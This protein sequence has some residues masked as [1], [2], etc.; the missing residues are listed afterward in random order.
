[1]AASL[2]ATANLTDEEPEQQSSSKCLLK[3]IQLSKCASQLDDVKTFFE[4]IA[5]ESLTDTAVVDLWYNNR[6]AFDNQYMAIFNAKFIME[7]I[8]AA[9][10]RRERLTKYPFGQNV[11]GYKIED[12]DLRI[13]RGPS[14]KKG[15]ALSRKDKRRFHKE[16]KRMAGSI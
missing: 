12:G 9:V 10:D 1:M 15:K 6:P 13:V 11:I 2:D 4:K 7:D 8:K 16:R 3:G 14:V 5:T